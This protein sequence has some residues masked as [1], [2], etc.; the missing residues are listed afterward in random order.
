MYNI[1]C[2]G[3]AYFCKTLK[4][5]NRI[6]NIFITIVF[7]T[8]FSGVRIFE[9]FSNGKL[10]CVEVFGEP[11]TCCGT[12]GSCDMNHLSF[13]RPETGNHSDCSCNNRT[14]VVSHQ[15]VFVSE[16]LLIPDVSSVDLF[17]T[18]TVDHREQDM[19]SNNLKTELHSLLP[20][21]IADTQAGHCL[22][23]C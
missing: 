5:M 11:E 22:F 18:E 9:H 2:N 12:S 21:Y 4:S 3:C 13:D 17:L 1:N 14:K 20:A 6:A 16:K 19:F 8:T 7:L 23:L 15:D 10:Y